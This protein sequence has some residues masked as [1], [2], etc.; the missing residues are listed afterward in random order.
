M[1]QNFRTANSKTGRG[2]EDP[3][4]KRL[5]HEKMKEAIRKCDEGFFD[6]GWAEHAG[7]FPL[8]LGYLNDI[9]Y[10]KHGIRVEAEGEQAEVINVDGDGDGDG[11]DLAG[12]EALGDVDPDDVDVEDVD[13][14]VDMDATQADSGAEE[15]GMVFS[16]ATTRVR[17]GILYLCSFFP[18]FYSMES[19]ITQQ[20]NRRIKSWGLAVFGRHWGTYRLMWLRA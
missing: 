17:K 5:R 9:T 15:L 7:A 14:D 13:M 19:H 20:G 2:A 12:E 1:R 8:Y 6:S 10:Y 4:Q 18:L 3:T 16:A 11:Q